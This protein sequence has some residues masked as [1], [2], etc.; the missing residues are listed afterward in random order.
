MNLLIDDYEKDLLIE[1]LEY[2]VENDDDLVLFDSKKEEL[3][4]LMRKIEEN[5]Y[6]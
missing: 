5:E 3:Q 2:R 4:E 1:T 6:E